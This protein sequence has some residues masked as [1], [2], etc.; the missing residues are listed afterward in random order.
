MAVLAASRLVKLDV[1]EQDEDGKTPTD[2]LTECTICTGS[3]KSLL[4]EY[5]RMLRSLPSQ[6]PTVVVS[7]S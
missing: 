1:A 5:A 7:K 3:E 4:E 6:K 2:Y